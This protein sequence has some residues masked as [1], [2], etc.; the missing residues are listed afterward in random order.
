MIGLIF[1]MMLSTGCVPMEPRFPIVVEVPIPFSISSMVS[2]VRAEVVASGVGGRASSDVDVD[3][4][5]DSSGRATARV[6]WWGERQKRRVPVGTYEVNVTS[7]MG[8]SSTCVTVARPVAA[9]SVD[10]VR[11]PQDPGVEVIVV[12]R[13]ERRGGTR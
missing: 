5:V 6:T 9:K 2:S 7:S 8:R 12:G 4:V 3:M 11:P 10:R 1:G 13:S